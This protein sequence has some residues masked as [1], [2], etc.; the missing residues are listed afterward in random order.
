MCSM[1]YNRA[2]K[3]M[4]IKKKILCV[5]TMLVMIPTVFCQS[6]NQ[7]MSNKTYMMMGID[8]NGNVKDVIEKF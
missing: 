1:G 7:H 4:R 5:I 8:C 2:T 6:N 3:K